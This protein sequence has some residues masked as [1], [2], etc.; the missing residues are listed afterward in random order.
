[1]DVY[2]LLVIHISQTIPGVLTSTVLI[3]SDEI[4]ALQMDGFSQKSLPNQDLMQVSIFGEHAGNIHPII[5][6]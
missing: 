4:D 5:A 1:M 6:R 3:T 2:R